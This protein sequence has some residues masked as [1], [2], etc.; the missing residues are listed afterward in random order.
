MPGGNGQKNILH[1]VIK[2]VLQHERDFLVA[3]QGTVFSVKIVGNEHQLLERAWR[4]GFQYRRVAAAHGIDS[5]RQT[6][7]LEL[8][9]QQRAGGAGQ[10]SAA[11]NVDDLK[12]GRSRRQRFSKTVQALGFAQKVFLR[13]CGKHWAPCRAQHL[14]DQIGRGPAGT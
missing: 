2:V 10:A 1:V 6:V 5:Q 3:Q 12:A 9:V 4:E 13:S 8:V 14:G 11:G 7:L